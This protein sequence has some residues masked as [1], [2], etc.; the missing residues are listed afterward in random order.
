MRY[1][2]LSRAQKRL[3]NRTIVRTHKR[4]IEMHV[5]TLNGRVVRSLTPKILTGTVTT[6]VESTPMQVLEMSLV[7]RRRALVFEP[8]GAGEAPLHRRYM[9]QVNDMRY[10][11][12]LGWVDCEVFTGP[13]WTF[14]RTGAEVKLT[15]HSVDRLAMGTI[16]RAKMWR[17]KTKKTDIIRG[18]LQEAGAT[19]LRIPDL[20][21]TTPVHVHV[22]V[23]HPD[24]K[25]EK[26]HK[27][28]RRTGFEVTH[29]NTYWDKASGLGDSMSR[30]LFPTADGAFDL[31]S[32]PERPVYHFNRALVSPVALE[33][34]TN[35]GPNTFI[36]VGGKPK[37]S[38]RR[39][40]SGKVGF[41]AGHPLSASQLAWHGKPYEVLDKTQNPHFKTIA[42]CKKVARRKRDR[43]ARMLTDVSF[44][45]LPIPWL[46]PWDMVTSAAGWG[47][48]SVHIRQ[49]TYPLTPDNSPM[50]IGSVKRATPSR[51]AGSRGTA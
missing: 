4:R 31:R 3:Y 16:R 25:G 45:A 32:H 43:A 5:L 35:D 44:D 33:R 49:M 38:K 2:N 34:P 36:V 23:T 15:A 40:S 12:T 18:L 42:E 8:D 48:P 7:D 11:P 6:D 51:F 29:Q 9:L 10:I 27:V 17:H 14:N 1:A 46:R 13:I 26:P 39:V 30:L 28:R 21:F 24:R 41:P 37:G 50:T 20:R 19:R 47:V 22:G